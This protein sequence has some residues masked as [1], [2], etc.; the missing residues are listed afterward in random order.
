MAK[1]KTLDIAQEFNIFAG[2]CI[3]ENAPPEA[4]LF[5]ETCFIAGA[6]V[7]MQFVE[8][9]GPKGSK[10][11]AQSTRTEIEQRFSFVLEAQ[12]QIEHERAAYAGADKIT[13]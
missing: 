2:E 1:N 7:L 10:G 3:P 6:A 5:A 11:F 8:I 12:R 9:H 4:R 13:Q